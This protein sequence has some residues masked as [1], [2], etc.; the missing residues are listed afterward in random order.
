ME[1]RAFLQVVAL[2]LLLALTLS[3]QGNPVH[4]SYRQPQDGR[5]I[6]DIVEL[7]SYPKEK[8]G[9][10]IFH[11]GYTVFYSSRYGVPL[12][13][14][15]EVNSERVK[16]AE[17]RFGYGFF[18]DPAL[19]DSLQANQK[20]YNR[21]G[22]DKGHM[23]PAN[24]NTGS[25]ELMRECHYASNLAPQRKELNRS[26]GTWFNVEQECTKFVKREGKKLYVICGPIIEHSTLSARQRLK[27]KS[28]YIPK[29]FFKVIMCEDAGV[30]YGMGLV[31]NQWNNMVAKSIREVEAMVGFNFFMNL[32]AREQDKFERSVGDNALFRGIK[33]NARIE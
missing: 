25:A 11:K 6:A 19:P 18:P 1:G 33:R 7:P 15:W 12:W 9:A 27:G 22:Y 16:A 5:R 13:V 8:G 2:S 23:C 17:G 26:G 29:H 21:T 20:D 31:F 32:P 3:A 14:A 4:I 24:D 10:L 28:A 30:R